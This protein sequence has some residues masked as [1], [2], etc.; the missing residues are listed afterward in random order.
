MAKFKGGAKSRQGEDIEW[1]GWGKERNGKERG[2]PRGG[3]PKRKGKG[4]EG[5]GREGKGR[6]LALIKLLSGTSGEA[7]Y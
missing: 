3:R 1:P 5:K 4:R 2:R 6:A 7:P